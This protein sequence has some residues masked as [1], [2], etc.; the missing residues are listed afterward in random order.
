[1]AVTFSMNQKTL[2][3]DN[4]Q[5]EKYC[6]SRFNKHNFYYKINSLNITYYLITIKDLIL[7]EIH[8]IIITLNAIYRK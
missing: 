5:A 2:F 3:I 6:F 4:I 1:M 8:L 7:P